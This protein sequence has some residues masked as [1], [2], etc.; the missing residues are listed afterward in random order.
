M[1][2]KRRNHKEIPTPQTEIRKHCKPSDLFSEIKYRLL[3][4]YLISSMFV[5]L[6]LRY[7]EKKKRKPKNV[8]FFFLSTEHFQRFFFFFF[9]FFSRPPDPKSEKKIP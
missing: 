6:F 4:Q 7:S 8:G 2:R 1:I 5:I 3:V 9:F